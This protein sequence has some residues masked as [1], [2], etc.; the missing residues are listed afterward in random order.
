MAYKRRKIMRG[1][2]LYLAKKEVRKTV[3]AKAETLPP[4]Y[5]KDAGLAMT[6]LIRDWPGFR[7]ARSVLAF[8]PIKGEVDIL[9]MVREILEAGKTLYL[10]R[11]DST[12]K[13][14]MSAVEVAS[15][16]DLVSG[17]WGI[18]EPAKDKPAASPQAI[19]LV[20]VPCLA[21]SRDGLRMGKGGG[22][23][24]RFMKGYRGETILLCPEAFI[25]DRVPMG[26]FDIAYSYVLTE[27]GIFKEGKQ[28]L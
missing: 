16:D 27:E 20:I 4:T 7:E 2:K 13:G 12:K 15:L 5:Y 18:R 19:D 24:D 23:Y 14:L 28:I 10:P 6:R 8:M 3:R 11:V 9:P 1:K 17:T 26:Y 21:A 22:F 25:L